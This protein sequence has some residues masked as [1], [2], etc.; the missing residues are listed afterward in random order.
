MEPKIKNK[1]AAKGFVV[2][3]VQIDEAENWPPEPDTEVCQ[4]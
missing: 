2:P 3:D 4:S 1:P